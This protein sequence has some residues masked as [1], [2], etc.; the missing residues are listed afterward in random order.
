MVTQKHDGWYGYMDFPS[1]Q[2]MSGR[3]REIPSLMN[4]GLELRSQLPK[5]RGRLIFEIM[6]EGLEN[7]FY[8]LN[9]I[10]NRKEDAENV[11]LMVHDFVPFDKEEREASARDRFNL[12]REMV[13]SI[14]RADV[15]LVDLLH[16]NATVK[17]AKQICSSIWDLGFEGVIMKDPTASYQEGKRNGTVMK[18]K[19]GV[20]LD[21]LIVG[22][23]MATKGSK[24]NGML[25]TLT[26]RERSGKEH[27]VSGMSDGDRE[28]WTRDF[29]SI[30][31]HVAEI[32]AMKRNKDGSLREARFKAIRWNKNA[33]DID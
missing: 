33:D 17:K 12:A 5:K 13:S 22:Y 18:I 19:E 3:G 26:V 16:Q 27:N 28:F 11:Y 2:I 25:G 6:I 23:K 24:Y 32:S 29:N 8:T 9:G 20:S 7:D 10:L 21:L 1:C 4:F 15:R 14:S 31:G 30:K